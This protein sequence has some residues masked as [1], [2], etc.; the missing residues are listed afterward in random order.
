MPVVFIFNKLGYFFYQGY[1]QP[2]LAIFIFYLLLIIAKNIGF[3][4]NSA[5][6]FGFS[7]ITSAF[8]ALIAIPWSWWFSQV[9]T[10]VLLLLAILEY[11]KRGRQW[12][13]GLLMGLVAA[14]RL[15]AGLGIIFFIL[16]IVFNKKNESAKDKIKACV[17]L[18]FPF[19]LI[20]ILL[21]F[22]NFYRFGNFLETG[23]ASQTIADLYSA[24][25]NYGV[26]SIIHLP[27]NLYYAFLATPQPVFRDGITHLL[28]FPF[29]KADPW[30]MSIFLT[31]PYLLTL[32][33]FKYKDSIS[34]ILWITIIAIALP[35]FLFFGIG[36]I[37]LG[38]RYAFDFM[39][40]VFL[41]FMR[42]YFREKGEISQGLRL[43][44]ILSAII[45]FYLFLTFIL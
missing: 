10:V 33:F 8:I 35:I 39:P 30:G 5:L 27:T 41:L 23:Y 3:S 25:R 19:I 44:I 38:Y 16:A 20:L 6:Y 26:F 14:S 37:Q 29:I 45:N 24:A 9:I 31:S 28:K 21:G 4:L 42:N 11:E 1:L 2:L 34:K 36:Y 12:I 18:L 32:F 40:F 17:R 43:T 13:M 22:Y 15:T 7:F